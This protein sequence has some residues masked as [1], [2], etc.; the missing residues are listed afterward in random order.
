MNL[1]PQCLDADATYQLLISAV[2]PRP[3]AWV[4]TLSPSGVVNLAPFSY[5]T[6]VCSKPPTLLF[7]PGVPGADGSEKDTLRNLRATG[8]FVVHLPDEATVDAMNR[9]A[10][11]FP[12]DI[13]E[14]EYSGVTTVPSQVVRVPRISE[15]LI[16]FECRLQRIVDVST[17]QGG[18]HAVFGEIVHVYCRDDAWQD[19]K[20]VA[21]RGVRSATRQAAIIFCRPTRRSHFTPRWCV[22]VS[23]WP[24]SCKF[25]SC[26]ATSSSRGSWSSSS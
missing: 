20:Y 14:L 8:D 6:A 2:V 22:S 18:G 13:S 23:T 10:I 12:P 5:F 4:S 3:I 11:N 16:A 15:A 17:N 1:D 24:A 19:N 7:C 26:C 25:G 21:R 9:S